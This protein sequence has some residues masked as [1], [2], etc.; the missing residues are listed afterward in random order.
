MMLVGDLNMCFLMLIVVM[1]VLLALLLYIVANSLFW[2]QVCC[3]LDGICLFRLHLMLMLSFRD[4]QG[5]LLVCLRGCLASLR[6]VPRIIRRPAIVIVHGR[7]KLSLI[8]IL[9]AFG[10]GAC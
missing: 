1:R 7:F 2:F 9:I 10:R 3:L 6:S 4:G 5:R 8:F